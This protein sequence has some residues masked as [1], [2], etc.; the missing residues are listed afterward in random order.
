[1]KLRDK[2]MA[3]RRNRILDAAERLIRETGGTDFSVRTLASVAEV[4]PATPFNLFLSKEGLLYALL[5][6]NLD[7]II[8]EGLRFKGTNRGLHIVEAATNAVDMFARDP[9]FMRPLYRVLLGVSDAVHRPQF[10]ARSLGYWRTAVN[11]IPDQALL[12][13]EFNRNMLATALQAHFLGLLEFWVHEE[14]DDDRFRKHAV[15]GICIN[16]LGLVDLENRAD[17]VGLLGQMLEGD[18]NFEVAA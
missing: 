5:S 1:M 9:A 4:A 17:Y 3:E 10:M 15:Y 14:F 7:S 18:T 11:T 12:A 6:R 8:S 16:V 2:Q 13:A